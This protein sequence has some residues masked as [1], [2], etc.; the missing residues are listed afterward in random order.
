VQ[1]RTNQFLPLATRTLSR[2]HSEGGGGLRPPNLSWQKDEEQ[3]FRIYHL[4]RYL[5]PIRLEYT[6]KEG[7][8]WEEWF[9][10]HTAMTLDE[11][12]KWSNEQRLKEKFRNVKH[13][14]HRIMVTQKEKIIGR[15]E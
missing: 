10:K 2:L 12:A 14:K 13:A 6:P 7:I 9:K 15:E 3:V 11:F 1:V 4:A 5:W 8:Q